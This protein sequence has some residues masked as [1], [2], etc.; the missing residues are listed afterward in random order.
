MTDI[1]I[2]R[3]VEFE[4]VFLKFKELRLIERFT[5]LVVLSAFVGFYADRVEGG[6]GHNPVQWQYFTQEEK[7]RL[8]ALTIAHT[9]RCGR[10]DPS[11]IS[12]PKRK[13]MFMVVEQYV[14]GGL[15]EMK[16]HGVLSDPS[17]VGYGS[18]L[19]SFVQRALND[20]AGPSAE[21]QVQDLL[22]DL[23]R[24]DAD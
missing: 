7:S 15:L 20:A 16:D 23:M 12:A 3:P 2:K 1:G 6:P 13:D 19:A 22:R 14:H 18:G 5:E 10:V 9:I 11:L 17:R 4:H 21:L 24:F 8:F